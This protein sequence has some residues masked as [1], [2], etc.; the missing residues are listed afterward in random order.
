MVKL[1]FNFAESFCAFAECL[2]AALGK[3]A[4]AEKIFTDTSLLRAALGKGFAKS[5]RQ[6]F[7][8]R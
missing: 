1:F 2:R 3:E 6:S 4:F 7:C 5:S 8:F